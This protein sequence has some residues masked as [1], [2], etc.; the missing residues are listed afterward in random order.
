MSTVW[1]VKSAEVTIEAAKNYMVISQQQI[2][3]QAT[4]NLL[5]IKQ[6][7]ISIACHVCTA[8]IFLRCRR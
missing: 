7:R 2:L 1:L 6:I 4:V 8:R 5:D 3:L